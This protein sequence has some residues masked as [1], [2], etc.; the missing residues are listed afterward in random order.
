MKKISILAVVFCLLLAALPAG[1]DS[2]WTPMDDYFMD[3]WDPQSDNTCGHESRPY[4]LAAG[5]AGYVASIKTPLNM[6]ILNIYPNGTEF[7]ISFICGKGNNL[8]GAVEAVRMPGKAAFIE[9]WRGESGYIPMKDLIRSFDADAFREAFASDIEPFDGESL[10]FCGLG[11]FV[12]WTAPN[13]GSQL[14]YVDRDYLGYLCMDVDP[15]SGYKMFHFG[16]SYTDPDGKVWVELTLRRISEH[17]WICLDR[18]TEGGE[19][20]VY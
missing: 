12:L 14:E 13:S 11:E 16:D 9:D 4:Y 19:K 8:Y 18:L 6:T 10:D 17:G 2:V 7:K 3:A 1:A 20:P 15:G 5:E